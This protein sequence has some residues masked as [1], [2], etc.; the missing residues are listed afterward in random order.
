MTIAL[1]LKINDGL[2][3]GTDSASTLMNKD[4]KSGQMLVYNVY[5]NANKIFNLYKGLPVGAVTWGLGSIENASIETLVKD[6]RLEISK[7]IDGNNYSVED[8]VK[9]FKSFIFEDHYEKIFKGTNDPNTFLGF[10][11]AGYSIKDSLKLQNPEIWLLD[12]VNGSCKDPV[13]FFPNNQAGVIWGGQTNPLIRIYNGY[14]PRLFDLLKESKIDDAK[15]KEIQQ[16]IQQRF[17]MNSVIPSMPIQD[18]INLVEY[19]VDMTEKYFKYIPEATTVG[20]PIEIAA[21]TKYEGFKWVKR[22]H[23]FSKEMNPED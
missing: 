7:E 14:D 20:G 15:I 4:P 9:K 23:Y 11:I 18:A 22:K 2:V 16:L 13:N 3:L 1:V 10:A 5:D 17:S 8:F 6:F 12:M 19:F 21:I